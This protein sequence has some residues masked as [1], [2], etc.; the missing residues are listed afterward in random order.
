MTQQVF[1]EIQA[2]AAALEKQIAITEAEIAEMKGAIKSK[3]QLVR[4]WRKAVSAVCPQ[5]TGR[6][7]RSA[8]N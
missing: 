2:A 1:P 5:E 7:K 6:K 3:K 4:A 8:A